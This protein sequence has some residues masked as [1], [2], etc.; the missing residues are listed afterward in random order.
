[1]IRQGDRAQANYRRSETLPLRMSLVLLYSLSFTPSIT[2]AEGKIYKRIIPNMRE[3]GFGR[4]WRSDSGREE[5][6]FENK[7]I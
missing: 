2:Y 3:K 5:K 4:G 6:C 7:E 1:M